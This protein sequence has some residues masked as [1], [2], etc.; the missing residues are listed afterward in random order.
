VDGAGKVWVIGSSLSTSFPTLGFPIF[1]LQE[2]SVTCAVFPRYFLSVFD[3]QNGDMEMSMALDFAIGS[4]SIDDLGFLY[5]G[6]NSERKDLPT[7]YPFQ[8]TSDCYLAKLDLSTFQF[9][10]SF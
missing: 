8:G 2:G 4:V 6:G 3:G 10:L 9:I 5:L 1:D 7:I